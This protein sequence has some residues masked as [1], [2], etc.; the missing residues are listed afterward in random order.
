MTENIF[1]SENVNITYSTLIEFHKNELE[2]TNSSKQNISNQISAFK[3]FMKFLKKENHDFIDIEFTAHFNENLSNHLETSNIA[4]KKSRKYHLKKLKN[5]YDDLI[6]IKTIPNDFG[7]AV[8]I[9]KDRSNLSVIEISKKINI[10]TDSIHKWM[11]IG[12]KPK[13]KSLPRI[14]NLEK[15]FEVPSG[16]LTRLLPTPLSSSDKKTRTEHGTRCGE[17]TKKK[18]GLKEP[19]KKLIDEW[20]GYVTFMSS[21]IT[22]PGY[23]RNLTWRLRDCDSYAKHIDDWNTI[24]NKVCVSGN[25]SW[26]MHSY[27]FGWLILPIKDGGKGLSIENLSLAHTSDVNLVWDYLQWRKERSGCFTNESKAFINSCMKFIRDDTGWGF[28]N[29]TMFAHEIGISEE[30][31][32]TWC[33]NNRKQMLSIDKD[34]EKNK[35][36]KKSRDPAAPIFNILSMDRPIDALYEL[37][38]R[39]AKNRPL[40]YYKPKTKAQF[41][42]NELLVNFLCANPLRLNMYTVMTYKEDG[43]GNLRKTLNG[44]WRLFFKSECFKNEKGAANKDYDVAIAKDLYPLIDE[45]IFQHRENLLNGVDSDIVFPVIPTKAN[46]DRWG[47]C[48]LNNSKTIHDLTFKYL[49]DYSSS[50]FS[51]HAFRHIIATDFLKNNPNGFQIVANILHDKLE[52]VLKDYSHLEVTDGVNHFL[53]YRDYCRNDYFSNNTAGLQA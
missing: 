15:L 30:N 49:S 50:G 2:K 6:L 10:G 27:F 36:Y 12:L 22:P 21:P 35:Q 18:Y 16:T 8:R 47:M 32:S 45:Y 14:I 38:N 17:L 26:G 42:K 44:E 53:Q 5:S 1:N 40:N 52:T 33:A 29:P 4:D 48:C 7:S 34:L 41:A 25:I 39:I 20:K 51:P 28:Q 13:Q 24:N 46:K 3:M 37:C 11:N 19:T 43:T 31:W 23:K 9:L